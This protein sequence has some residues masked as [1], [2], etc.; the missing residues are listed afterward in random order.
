MSK[1]IKVTQ[2]CLDEIRR[3]F[4]EALSSGKFSD[5]K[6][7]FTKTIGALDRK[8]TVYFTELAWLKM[9]TLVREFDK[10]VAW[11]GIAKRCDDPEKDEYIIS[12]ILVYPQ[13]VTGATV[14]TDQ[15]KYQM[16]LMGHEDDVFNNIRFQG[17]S[18]V[19]MQTSPSA[20]DTTLYNGILEQL[21][22]DMFYIF[23][24]W[25]KRKEK[26]VKIYD[27]AKN[28]LFETADVSIEVINDGTGIEKWLADAKE[29]VV[30]KPYTY[31]QPSSYGGS[32]GNGYGSGCGGNYGGYN[33]GKYVGNMPYTPAAQTAQKNEK[34]GKNDDK[35]SGGK[36][37]GKRKGKRKK[38][39]N[40]A[41][42]SRQLTLLPGINDDD[43]DWD[44]P[45][46]CQ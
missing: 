17:H 44:S 26:T 23:M 18:H 24:I 7:T 45:Y 15:Q 21:T 30:D 33:G 8:A 16:W 39:N 20:V 19:N 42:S 38:D 43:E 5:G 6:V 32:Y 29:M 1:L 34:D 13:E 25:N 22:D 40:N 9:Q 27:M 36:S 46:Y 41:C 28:V 2:E 3:D 35:K 4:E 37:S 10:E 12:D 11:H 14:T 31:T